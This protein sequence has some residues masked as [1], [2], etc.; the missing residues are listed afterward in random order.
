MTPSS[1]ALNLE[2][3]DQ[4]LDQHAARCTGEIVEIRLNPFEVERLG[5]EEFKGIPI[6]ADDKIST[7]RFRL[8]CEREQAGGDLARAS[9]AKSVPVAA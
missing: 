8:I 1:T 6:V 3:I 7:G 5:F 9:D 2:A 4:A